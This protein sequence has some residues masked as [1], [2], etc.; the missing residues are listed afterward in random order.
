MKLISTSSG[1]RRG[2]S[3]NSTQASF[4]LTA[5]RYAISRTTVGGV[6]TITDG[7]NVH[8][9]VPMD[10]FRGMRVGFGGV[11][12]NNDT[13]D[14][15]LYAVNFGLLLGKRNPI[16]DLSDAADCDVVPYLT[17]SITLGTKTGITGDLGLYLSTEKIAD[18]VTATLA[19]TATTPKGIGSDSET[20]RQLGTTGA[21]SEANNAGGAKVLIPDF[22]GNQAFL[23]EFDLTGTTT[24][25]NFDHDRTL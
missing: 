22:G 6:A 19:S 9:I 1:Q 14:Y 15:R 12:A 11:G 21:Y 23:I 13:A 2:L 24:S 4:T 18:T 16:A 17:G 10:I 7:T 20:A 8:Q 25:M 3:A 5:G